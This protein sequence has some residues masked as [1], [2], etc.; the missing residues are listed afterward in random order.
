MLAQV[1]QQ[2]REAGITA[3]VRPFIEDMARAYSSASL[4]IARSGATT[5][6]EMCA[7]GRPSILIPYPH[8]SDDHQGKNAIALEQAGAAIVIREQALTVDGLAQTVNGLIDDPDRR[9]SMAEA[10]RSQGR[11]EAAAAIVD[12]LCSWLGY[13]TA[14]S[15]QADEPVCE[16]THDTDDDSE[17][18]PTIRRVR[19]AA[20]RRP[21]VRRCQLRIKTMG[22]SIDA[23]G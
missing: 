12:D 4:V 9:R 2:Y 16:Q 17:N 10:A 22:C 23:T 13:P 6:A 5:L 1:E 8:H 18:P 11:P 3:E 19:V 14:K 21:K 20:H 7:I 15:F